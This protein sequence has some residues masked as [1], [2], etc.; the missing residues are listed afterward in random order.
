MCKLNKISSTVACV[1]PEVQDHC[2]L[3]KHEQIM[4]FGLR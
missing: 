2:L 1:L 4:S 3:L